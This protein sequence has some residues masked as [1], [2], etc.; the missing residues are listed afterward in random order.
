MG[1]S[2]IVR[3]VALLIAVVAAF[4]N[5]PEE[6]AIVALAGVV[7][8]Y[9]IEEEYASRF[10]IGTLALAMVHGSLQAIWGIGPYLSAILA[11]VSSLFN[12]AA[13]TVIVMGVVNRLKP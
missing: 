2:K 7:G 11:S 9:F 1:L 8:G 13:C 10:L 12:A 4:V 5:L 6:A 3:L